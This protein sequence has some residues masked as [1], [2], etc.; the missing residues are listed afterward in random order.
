MS[1]H[2]YKAG[3]RASYA[4]SGMAARSA[5]YAEYEIVRRLPVDGLEPLY[6]IKAIGGVQERVAKEV[7]LRLL[8]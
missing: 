8:G 1:T 3:Q 2:K 6:R 4:P 7:E 5:E